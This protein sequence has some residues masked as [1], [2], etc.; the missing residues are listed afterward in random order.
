M[1]T[2]IDL[3]VIEQFFDYLDITGLLQIIHF[4]MLVYRCRERFFLP[5]SPIYFQQ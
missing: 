2:R 3:D 4:Y 1:T 5:S